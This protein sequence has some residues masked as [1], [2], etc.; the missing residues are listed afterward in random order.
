MTHNYVLRVDDEHEFELSNEQINHLDLVVLSSKKTHLR[1]QNH[2]YHIEFLESD[3]LNKNYTVKVNGTIHKV[4]I[5]T[6]LDALIKEMGLS[7][8]SAQTDDVVYA[9]M[10]GIILEVL[11]KEGDVVSRGDYLCVLEAMK[12]EN[13]L[14]A[15]RDGKIKS[16]TIQK[17]DTVEK[18]KLLIEFETD[19][20]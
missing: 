5:H 2:S 14:A 13:A 17:G 1:H 6:P 10:P 11:V 18:G 19:D 9:P 4:A 7:L 15:P 8:G 12:M 3:F 20:Q 16:V